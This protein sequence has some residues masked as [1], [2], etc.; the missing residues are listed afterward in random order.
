M[1]G[2]CNLKIR[3]KT[4][5]L[6]QQLH[7]HYTWHCNKKKNLVTACAVYA[8]VFCNFLRLPFCWMWQCASYSLEC[9]MLQNIEETSLPFLVTLNP[10]HTPEH[11]LFKWSTSHPVPSVAA[12]KASFELDHIQGK[13]GIWFCGAYQGE[14]YYTIYKCWSFS[15]NY[16]NNLANF[17]AEQYGTRNKQ[18][19]PISNC[20]IL[21]H[22]WRRKLQIRC[23]YL[24]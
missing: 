6:K 18:D 19:K 2:T 13:R 12:S 16:S 15:F 17:R 14:Q 5:C 1:R 21:K 4:V 9:L 24:K 8:E 10:D 20:Y 22:S 11:T 7:Y 23:Y 3:N